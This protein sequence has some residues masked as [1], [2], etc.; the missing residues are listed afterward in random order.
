MFG[1][2]KFVDVAAVPLIFKGIIDV[3]SKP[4]QDPAGELTFLLWLLVGAY[5]VTN[6]VFRVGDYFMV[7]SQSKILEDLANYVLEKLQNH[8]YTFFTNSFTGGLIAKARR[9]VNA[10]EMLHDQLVYSIWFGLVTLV[11]STA[12]LFFH[13]PALGG[14]FFLWLVTYIL[15]IRYLIKYQIPKSLANAEADTKMTAHLSDIISNF[16]T[17]MMFG[18]RAREAEEFTKT[19]AY[20]QEKRR[21]AWMQESFWNGM[22]QG[23]NINGFT[24]L[25]LAIAV[26]LWLQGTI[27]AGTIVL[28]QIYAITSFGVVWNLSKNFIRISTALTDANE[29]VAII[30][31][32]VGVKDPSKAERVKIDGGE[33]TF[34]D[35]QFRYE[36]NANVFNGLDLHIRS[37]EK[38]A[39]V[40]H[41]GAGKSTITKLLLRFNDIETGTIT[42]DGQDITK[43]KQDE[44]RAKIAYVPQ[45]PLLFHRTLWENIAYAKPDAT[46]EEVKEVARRAHAHEF[47]SVLPKQYD[48]LVG[49]R[50]VKLS[51]GERQRVAVARAMLKD[52]PII[53]LDEATSALDSVSE[54]MIQEGFEELM[55]GKTTIVIAHRLSTIQ[56]MDRIIVFDKGR[57][58]EDGTHH[59][60]RKAGGVYQELWEH[61]A[62]GFIQD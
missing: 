57:I 15:M 49:E 37:G 4:S 44:L 53:M 1:I 24:V 13:S 10:F 41:S 9:F 58:V 27:T 16:F 52:A 2:G 28:M 61:Q 54:K 38:V 40:G 3:V 19:A 33:I 26:W 62:G 43:V 55:K 36:D 11:T 56:K 18:S 29:M 35:V 5:V 8:S 30:D 7:T 34:S 32:D 17:V 6:I 12:V 51:G 14:A 42:I 46:D 39:L 20:Q 50:G 47:I 60:L 25:F 59:E 45:E 22:W 23:V 31:K 21:I 48:T